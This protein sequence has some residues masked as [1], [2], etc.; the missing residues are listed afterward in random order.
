MQ[1]RRQERMLNL[2]PF[3]FISLDGGLYKTL[4]NKE[5]LAV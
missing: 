4:K 5:D 2:K 1:H 3:V